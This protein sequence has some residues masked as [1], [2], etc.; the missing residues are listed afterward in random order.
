MTET[1]D[2]AESESTGSAD[3]AA[4]EPHRKWGRTHT[5]WL[6]IALS[7][8][9]GVVVAMFREEWTALPA[10]LRAV[11]YFL[12]GVLVIAACGLIVTGGGK[13]DS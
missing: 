11:A 3:P 10:H 9:P 2:R 7:F 1:L 6:L 4:A 13:R 8:V 12:S 5:I